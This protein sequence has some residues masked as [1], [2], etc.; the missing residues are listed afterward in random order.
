MRY[1]LDSFLPIGAFEHCGNR[2]IRL[3]GGGGGI[4]SA[5]TNPISSVLGTDGSGNGIKGAV[6]SATQ[7][8][9]KAVSDVGQAAVKV[10][11]Q[12]GDV[13]VNDIKT[14]GDIGTNLA[15]GQIGGA[16]KAVMNGVI[17]DI[18]ILTGGSANPQR[19]QTNQTL[20]APGAGSQTIVAGN[21]QQNATSLN[22]QSV[23]GAPQGSGSLT[24]RTISG[25][26]NTYKL[27]KS[28]MLGL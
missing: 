16:L 7:A 13:V 10:G 19:P 25:P 28:T 5:V 26:D 12:V 14:I 4:V 17:G 22:D 9:G 24:T 15:H 1:G 3:Y 11:Q 27:N 6:D 2:H 23:L 20:G 18:G 8:V 21:T